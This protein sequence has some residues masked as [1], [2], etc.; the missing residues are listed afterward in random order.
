MTTPGIS[1]HCCKDPIFEEGHSG[2]E[3]H[4]A[5]F[6]KWSKES[7]HRF[8]Y[9]HSYD[10]NNNVILPSPDIFPKS[11]SSA[12][13]TKDNDDDGGDPNNEPEIEPLRMMDVFAGVGGLSIGLE[14]V[15]SL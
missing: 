9:C 14:Q 12:N 1:R 8:L 11:S 3:N 2:G 7:E 4:A 10:R 5:S 15:C 13:S 6:F